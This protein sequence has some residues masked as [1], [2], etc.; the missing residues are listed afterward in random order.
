VRLL[1][2]SRFLVTRTYLS[3]APRRL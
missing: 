3:V 2:L 1:K